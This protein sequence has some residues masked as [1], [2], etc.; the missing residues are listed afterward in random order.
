[1][2]FF[3]AL[4]F[5]LAVCGFASAQGFDG[6]WVPTQYDANNATLSNLESYGYEVA[7]DRATQ[8]GY[9]NGDWVYQQVNGLDILIGE[10]TNYYR[11]TV[12]IEQGSQGT[13]DLIFVVSDPPLTFVSWQIN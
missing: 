4:V 9:D 8:S 5:A 12:E 7:I 13:A 11:F 2:K 6:G 10:G 3:I 1:M